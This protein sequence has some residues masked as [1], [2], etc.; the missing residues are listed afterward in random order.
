VKSVSF[1]L[2]SGIKTVQ[3][4]DGSVHKESIDSGTVSKLSAEPPGA[5]LTG[6]VD[7]VRKPKP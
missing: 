6:F 5:S 1:D 2:S 3:M 4:T 7:Q